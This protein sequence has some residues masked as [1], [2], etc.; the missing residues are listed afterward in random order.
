MEISKSITVTAESHLVSERILYIEVVHELFNQLE[1]VELAHYKYGY[2]FYENT[3][4]LHKKNVGRLE[5]SMDDV[6]RMKV[7]VEV[8]TTISHALHYV[9]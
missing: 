8:D 5:V 9:K 7:S 6:T 3:P 4:A 2:C 1:V